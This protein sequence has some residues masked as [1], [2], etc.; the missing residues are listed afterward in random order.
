[1]RASG[2]VSGALLALF[3]IL[4]S[5]VYGKEGKQMM[6]I[7]D[8]VVSLETG[9]IYT[10]AQKAIS[11]GQF[12]GAEPLL[13]NFL[14]KQPKSKAGRY[15]YA[16]VLIQQNKNKEA[17]EQAKRCTELDPQFVGGWALLGESYLNLDLKDEAERAFKKALALEPEGENASLMR[18][19]LEELASDSESRNQSQSRSELVPSAM[20]DENRK[21]ASV[22]EALLLC[23][24]ANEYLKQKQYELGLEQC[25]L[26]LKKAPDCDR[27]RENYAVYLNNYAAACV[28]NNELMQ[29]EKLMKE[30]ISFQSGG[31]VSVDCRRTTLKNYRA[32]LNFLN[33]PEEARALPTDP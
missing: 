17:L 26:A 7:G 10:A 25:R 23:N 2:P 1:M 13:E 8:E 32:L 3:F 11:S 29:A 24:K 4:L 31:G 12:A 33:R 5:P 28:N 14:A 21:I 30:S 18:E 9:A 6:K 16:F 15:K 19:R 22:N 27:I 20:S